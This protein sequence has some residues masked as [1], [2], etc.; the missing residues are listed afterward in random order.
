VVPVRKVKDDQ[1]LEKRKNRKRQAEETD[2]STKT[3]VALKRTGIALN[4]AT[5]E[6]RKR[7]AGRSGRAPG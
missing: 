2:R 1:Q 3:G 7:A 4:K 5:R 6:T